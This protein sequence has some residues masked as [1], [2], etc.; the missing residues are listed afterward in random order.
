MKILAAEDTPSLRALLQL[1]LARAGYEV[2]FAEDGRDALDRFVSRRYDLVVLDIQMPVMDGLEAIRHIR[3]W[4]KQQGRAPVPVLALT[5][6]TESADLRKCVEAG[7]TA[8]LRKPFG[9]EELLTAV[10]RGLA[11]ESAAP[12]PGGEITVEA[13]PEFADLIPRFLEHC[14]SDA[15]AMRQA[16]DRREYAVIIAA[17]HRIV[18]AGA[19]Y[20]FQPLSDESR[21]IEEAAKSGDGA[22]VLEHLG[23]LD[24]YLGRVQVVYGHE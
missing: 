19:S 4:E 15:A 16:L 10:A 9:R 17:S 22:D 20:G 12:S 24:A 7:C 11:A 2:D 8:T 3:E 5:A 18:G 1:C 14:R 6:N 21:L 13:D 23:K